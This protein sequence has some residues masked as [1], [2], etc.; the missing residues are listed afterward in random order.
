MKIDPKDYH[1][2]SFKQTA[3]P[4]TIFHI[5][6][7]ISRVGKFNTDEKLLVQAAFL[8]G[9]T[10]P[11]ITIEVSIGDL[12]RNLLDGSQVLSISTQDYYQYIY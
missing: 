6:G 3:L 9:N 2:F 10:F 5:F 4:E 7:I 1:S 12:S 8:N 11:T